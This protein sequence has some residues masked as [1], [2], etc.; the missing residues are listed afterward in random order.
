MDNRSLSNRKILLIVGGGIAAYKALELVR[1][2]AKAGAQ[3][4]VILTES[5]AQFVNRSDSLRCGSW[6]GRGCV[7]I[8]P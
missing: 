1:L 4:R 7:R 3:T 5:G 6:E 2:I 8:R